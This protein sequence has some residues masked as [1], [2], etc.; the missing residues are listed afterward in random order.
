MHKAEL[1]RAPC[2]RTGPKFPA[3]VPVGKYGD[4]S[5][6]NLSD[7]GRESQHGNE[8]DESPGRVIEALI[9][10]RRLARYE[11]N[12]RW[13]KHRVPGLAYVFGELQKEYQQAQESE[14]PDQEYRLG[15]ILDNCC[16]FYP[17]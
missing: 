12:G 6:H 17:R 1:D 14:N 5:N 4:D 10:I 9:L 3:G 11:Q 8:R 13:S 16:E 2:E 15:Q 7:E